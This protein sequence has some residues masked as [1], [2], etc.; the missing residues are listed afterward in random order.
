MGNYC[1]NRGIWRFWAGLVCLGVPLL[2]C[3]HMR[4][5]SHAREIR[6]STKSERMVP[7][8]HGAPYSPRQMAASIVPPHP[9]MAKHG[10]SC[11]HSDPF[12][13]NTYA[14]PGPLGHS[15]EVSSR[16]MGF[17]GGRR[18]IKNKNSKARIVTVCVRDR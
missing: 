2:G 11:M 10:A 14:W 4:E 7:A 17:L 12:T 1:G 13:T 9:F 16:A 5:G 8:R 18:I 6:S 3:G 15:P